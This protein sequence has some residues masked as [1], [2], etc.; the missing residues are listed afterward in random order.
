MITD[1]WTETFIEEFSEKEIQEFQEIV[2]RDIR[3][4]CFNDH[5]KEILRSNLDLWIYNL[6]IIRKETELKLSQI[7]TNIKIKMLE[8]HDAN[9]TE[10]ERQNTLIIEQTRRNNTIKFLGHVEQRMLYVKLLL[11]Q[12]TEN[13]NDI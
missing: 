13:S 2:L 5:E 10:K 12:D 4:K 6:R 7:K 3:N 8:L 11:Q 1:I 9:I